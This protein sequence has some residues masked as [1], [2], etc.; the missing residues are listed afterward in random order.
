MSLFDAA[1][2]V[3]IADVARIIK[4]VGTDPIMNAAPQYLASIEYLLPALLDTFTA[5][6]AAPTPQKPARSSL[7]S[8]AMEA[9]L[10]ALSFDDIDFAPEGVVSL[11]FRLKL[12]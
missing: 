8:V 5:Q 11:W 6:N 12:L 7:P 1:D 4:T 9:P 10:P 3:R 2:P